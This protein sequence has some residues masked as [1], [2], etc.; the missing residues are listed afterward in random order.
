MG[1]ES[2]AG[3]ERNSVILKDKPINKYIKGQVS[4]KAR[5]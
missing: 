1:Y 5:Y 3:E 2:K 4:P